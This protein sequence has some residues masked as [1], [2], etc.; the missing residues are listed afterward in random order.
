[1]SNLPMEVVEMLGQT[2]AK[3]VPVTIALALVFTGSAITYF[4][5]TSSAGGTRLTVQVPTGAVTGL[6]SVVGSPSRDVRS[7]AVLFV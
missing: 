3:V 1:M 7:C 4:Y 5:A 2:I 6:V